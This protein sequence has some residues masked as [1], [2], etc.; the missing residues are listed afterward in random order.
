[1]GSRLNFCKREQGTSPS[2]LSLCIEIQNATLEIQSVSQ[3]RHIETFL[4]AVSVRSVLGFFLYIYSL[5]CLEDYEEK[6]MGNLLS[7]E[8]WCR[9]NVSIPALCHNNRAM[10]FSFRNQ[11]EEIMSHC[12]LMAITKLPYVH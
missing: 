8:V 12:S 10:I 5:Y 3:Y 9:S 1:M 7:R 2:L 11:Q 6:S 4:K